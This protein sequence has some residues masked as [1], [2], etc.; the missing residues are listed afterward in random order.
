MKLNKALT[1]RQQKVYDFVRS[2]LESTGMPPTRA[3]IAK[4]LG[5]RSPNAAEE[6]LKALARKGV[7]EILSGTSRGIRLLLNEEQSAV[8]EEEEGLPLIGRVAAG[9]P[10]LAQQHIEGSYKVDASMFK[11]QAHFLLKVYGMSMK[12]IGILDGDML[13]VHRT[14]D[15]RNGQVVVARIEDEVTVKRLEKKGSTVYLHAENEE[16]K[17][18][19]VDLKTEQLEIEGIA[20]GIIRNNAWM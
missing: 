1:P 5:F 2:H 19:V 3:E 7:I 16:F 15:V 8:E 17:P 13:A 11:P 12:D 10:I 20:V 14:Q 6:H 4:E 18:I 9:A